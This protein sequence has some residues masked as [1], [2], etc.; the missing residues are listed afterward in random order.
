[1]AH[2]GF[3]EISARI[4][5]LLQ[6]RILVLDGAMGTMIQDLK[7]DEKGFR[8]AHFADWKRDLKGNND[9]LNL[10]QPD[11]IRDIHLAYFLAGATLVESIFPHAG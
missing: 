8:G 1:M 7:L 2:A 9:L 5:Q 3:D 11:A 6:E 4:V 10:T